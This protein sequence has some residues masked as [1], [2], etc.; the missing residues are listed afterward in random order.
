M[1]GDWIKMRT[2]IR[3]HPKVIAM[4]RFLT[5]Q[6]DF[7]NWW[8][9]PSRVTCRDS[10]T[11]IV[12]FENVTRV[13]VCGLLEVWGSLNSVIKDD[14]CVEFMRLI[15]LDD[16]AGIPLFGAALES[17]GWVATF[18]QETGQGL[19][20]PNFGEFNTPDSERKKP[21]TQAER[22][23][24]YRERKKAESPNDDRH[25][26]SQNVTQSSRNVTRLREEKRR[27]DINTKTIPSTSVDG[28][29][30]KNQ[31]D[32]SPPE[33]PKVTKFKF[34]DEQYQLA[35]AL[36]CPSKKR[37][38]EVLKINLDQWAD[39]IR[40][41]NEIDDKP[42]TDIA[43]L[44]RWIVNHDRGNFSWAAN[45]RTPMKLRERKDG[46]AYFDIISNQMH[47][48]V[49]YASNRS[50]QTSTGNRHQGRESLVDRVERKSEEWL[51]QRQAGDAQQG[52]DIDGEVV[53]DDEPS[54][55]LQVR[56]PVR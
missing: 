18:N 32:D 2:G 3:R 36:S 14:N 27:E 46:M 41:L 29:C 20:F 15:D 53:A 22:A 34:S 28:A 25:E 10:V 13:T 44:W 1:A 55:R 11:E 38:G 17:V 43:A 12:T 50:E 42:L 31:S 48:E 56:E 49:S 8:S 5:G 39:A 30:N 4:T 51:R 9:D 33:K 47:R 45:C 52:R 24:E 16:I 35:V 23:R 54:L 6:R 40:K 19:E 37:F 21:K 26:T 7:I